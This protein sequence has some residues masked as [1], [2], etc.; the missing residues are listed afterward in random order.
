MR[1]AFP[2]NIRRRSEITVVVDDPELSQWLE[3]QAILYDYELVYGY[4]KGD[5]YAALWFNAGAVAVIEGGQIVGILAK[6]FTA[7]FQRR[8]ICTKSACAPLKYGF[9]PPLSA[10]KFDNE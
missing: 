1:N 10:S 3:V 7:N 8:V 9:F 5:K 4:V 2:S 6:D